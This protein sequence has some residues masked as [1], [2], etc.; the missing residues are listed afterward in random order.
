[1]RAR[2]AHYS[3]VRVGPRSR[4]VETRHRTA[5]RQL[6]LY[7]QRIPGQ[8]PLSLYARRELYR[9]WRRTQPFYFSACAQRK[10]KNEPDLERGSAL[11]LGNNHGKRLCA[12]NGQRL[13]AWM[14]L[15][16]LLLAKLSPR[17]SVSG[18]D[19]HTLLAQGHGAERGT[20]PHKM[21]LLLRPSRP[22]LRKRAVIPA[23][24]GFSWE[25]NRLADSM[26]CWMVRF[27]LP[28]PCAKSERPPPPASSRKD[29][30]SLRQVTA[31]YASLR[32]SET[33][34]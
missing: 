6:R 30:I 17:R 28:P 4:G 8:C 19:D 34:T 7:R 10:R 23:Y 33:P 24:V 15:P 14:L 32:F 5:R 22:L 31:E 20:K 3:H 11:F 18:R 2:Y 12:W 27:P 29:R 21:L 1:M 13:R 9:R 16:S 25:R 26:A